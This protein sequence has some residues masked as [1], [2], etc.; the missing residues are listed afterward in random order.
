MRQGVTGFLV[1]RVTDAAAQMVDVSAT[2]WQD[3]SDR[4]HYGCFQ[5]SY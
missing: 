2:G 5:F 3:I 4:S 1:D